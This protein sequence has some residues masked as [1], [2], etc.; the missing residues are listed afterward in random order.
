MAAYVTLHKGPD[1][2]QVRTEHADH[3]RQFGYRPAVNATPVAAPETP[4]PAT[5]GEAGAEETFT[6]TIPAEVNETPTTPKRAPAK[7]RARKNTQE[8]HNG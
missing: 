7:R 6:F 5:S 2:I 8:S 3:W 1:R 4:G